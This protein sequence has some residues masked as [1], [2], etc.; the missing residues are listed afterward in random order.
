MTLALKL[1]LGPLLL[2]QGRWTR[3]RTPVLPEAEGAREG[4]C[5]SGTALRLLI[6]GD[7][8]AAGV[9]VSTQEVAL[10]GQLTRALA[11]ASGRCV[12]WRLVARSGAT[13]AQ[14][15]ELL[16]EAA[17]HRPADIAVAVLG[18]NDVVDQVPPPRALQARAALTDWLRRETGARHVV[19]A[20]LPPM[21]RFPALPQPL[22][23]VMGLDARRHDR[24]LKQWC[25]GRKD[26]SY[27]WMG[28]DLSPEVMAHDGFHP[29]E[30]VYRH[31]GHALARHIVSYRLI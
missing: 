23:A 4:R 18:V 31:C 22:R 24:A 20:A 19:H 3:W 25:E 7:S 10:A 28:M 8:S 16:R 14:A 5:G 29:A 2:A 26:A 1:A 17:P 6:V 9:G 11:Q 12:H 30:P 21:H 15:L 27:A 13:T